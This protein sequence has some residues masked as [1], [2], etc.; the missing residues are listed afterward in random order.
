[1]HFINW[2]AAAKAEAL[3]KA[4]VVVDSLPPADAPRR[5]ENTRAK[6]ELTFTVVFY[7]RAKFRCLVE[8]GFHTGCDALDQLI[9]ASDQFQFAA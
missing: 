3:A 4:K 5:E 6:R 8:Q 9:Q 7:G 1:L 2:L